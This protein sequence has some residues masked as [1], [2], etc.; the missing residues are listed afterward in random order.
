MENP[1]IQET[2]GQELQKQPYEPPKAIFV[3]LKLQERLLGCGPNSS[4][5]GIG[6]IP[7][8]NFSS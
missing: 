1:E 3:P 5:P 6:C 8:Q 4:V 7:Y 2:K